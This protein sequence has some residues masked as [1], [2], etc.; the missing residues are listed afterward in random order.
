MPPA[1]Q[2]P[3][4][5]PGHERP[6]PPRRAT[7]WA[8]QLGAFSNRAKAEQLV[9]EL[10]KRRY[11]AFVLE[12]RAVGPG[13]VP[14]P[15]RARNRIARAPRRSPR[16]SQ[17]TD[18]SRSS[19]GTPDR[20]EC[21]TF[22]G[23]PQGPMDGAD[24]IFAIIL[25]VSGAVG[26]FRGFIR[27]SIALVAWL[28]GL[29]LAWHFAYLVNPWL[30]GA[31]AE[32]GCARMDRPRDRA[33][34]R[35]PDRLRSSAASSRISRAA[36]W[37]S[38]RWTGCSALVFGLVRGVVIIGLLVLAG[39]AVNLD[40]EPWWERDAFDAC[41]RGGRELA[42][43]LRA[44][45]PP[46][47]FTTRPPTSRR[48]PELMCGLVGIVGTSAVNQRIY[49]ALTVLQHRGQDAAGIMTMDEHALF[50]RKDAGLVR[51]VF[52]EEDM[53]QLVGNAGIGHVRYPDRRLRRRR[54][55]AAVLRQ[56]AVRHRARPQ[57]QPDERRGAL[58]H[59]GRG[60]P[61]PPQH[62]LGLRGA[63]QRFRERAAALDC[64]ASRRRPTC[65]ARSRACSGAAAAATR[66]S[67]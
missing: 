28:L 24:H 6:Q 54:R 57:R 36:P 52:R 15:R 5:N 42:R 58:A 16:G 32:P 56:C 45:R 2:P 53:R 9:A 41:R 43:A 34:D 22:R 19:R 65:S 12:Y 31:L 39:R 23:G 18:S 21:R 8:V 49:D 27:E 13:A 17:R 30:G 35:A 44:S 67:C 38:P 46:S 61:P 40:L 66:S 7:A 62:A 11:A 25:L 14:R 10:R 48:R 29:W 55:G 50:V 3:Q 59:D 60:G 63:A 37:A 64:V 4:R 47:S 1:T 20:L 26:Y 51:D 33:A